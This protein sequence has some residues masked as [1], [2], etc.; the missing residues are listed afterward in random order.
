MR[1][2]FYI[3][4]DT[5]EMTRK[6]YENFLIDY[7]NENELFDLRNLLGDGAMG[8]EHHVKHHPLRLGREIGFKVEFFEVRG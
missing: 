3:I 5:M 6:E 4:N 8:V 7:I 1:R 2:A